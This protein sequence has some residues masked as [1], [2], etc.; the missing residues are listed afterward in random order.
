M[1]VT[2]NDNLRIKYT[3]INLVQD[4]SMYFIKTLNCNF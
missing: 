3:V 2:L 1:K 4:V